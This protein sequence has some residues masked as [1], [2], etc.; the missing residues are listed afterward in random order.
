MAIR[1]ITYDG[2]P[3][4]SVDTEEEYAQVFDSG[5]PIQAPREVFAAYGIPGS[6]EN[7]DPIDYGDPTDNPGFPAELIDLADEDRE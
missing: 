6:D 4:V 3:A 1:H 5:L 7:G 2:K